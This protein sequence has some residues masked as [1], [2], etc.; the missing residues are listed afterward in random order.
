MLLTNENLSDKSIIFKNN[1]SYQTNVSLIRNNFSFNN[2]EEN[3]P[4]NNISLSVAGMTDSGPKGIIYSFTPQKI[5]LTESNKENSLLKLNMVNDNKLK[6]E[7]NTLMIIANTFDNDNL[8]TSILQP[9]PISIIK[10]D[11]S[12]AGSSSSPPSSTLEETTA[13]YKN[14][15]A[16]KNSNSSK[17][18]II[19]IIKYLSLSIAIIL[20]GFII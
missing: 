6:S 7:N 18:N 1:T 14:Y 9:L 11:D 2:Q 12:Y 20:V 5:N 10:L 15:N 8:T 19:D 16:I 4:L 17:I 3:L 13:N